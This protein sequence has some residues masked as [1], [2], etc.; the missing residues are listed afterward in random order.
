MPNFINNN[1][2]FTPKLQPEYFVGAIKK[3]ATLNG[4]YLRVLPNITKDTLVKKLV[5]SG[6]TVSQTDT[7]DCQWHPVQRVSID[8]KKM[9]VANFKI[10][11]EQ[12]TDQLD[13]LFSEEVYNSIGANKTSLPEGLETVLMQAIQT[14][15]GA[16]IEKIIW[17]GA[18]NAVDDW[19]HG[20]IDKALADPD[21]I[22]VEGVTLSCDNILSEI[23]KVYD[24]LPNHVL[25]ENLYD[26]E[27]AKVSIFVDFNAYKY[28]RQAL[29]TTPTQ[30]EVIL[31]SFTYVDNV[32]S[33]LG[34]EIVPAG[35]P[36]NTI[37]AGSKDNLVFLTDLLSDT[38]SI[39]AAM[40]NNVT[41]DEIWRVKG[42]YRANADYIFSDEVVVYSIFSDEAKKKDENILNKILKHS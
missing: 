10:N 39:K 6:G 30:Y 29:S 15:L 5:L 17:G 41:D 27:R 26:P 8:S 33:Y 34:I 23:Q 18:G 22:K 38:V 32:I 36:A 11:L 25:G 35:L 20:L 19:Q 3:G 2:E 13:S 9:S 42:K 4:G 14:S 37:F 31:P 40:G 28:L 12:C 21:T 1:I 24:A 16:D 7:R